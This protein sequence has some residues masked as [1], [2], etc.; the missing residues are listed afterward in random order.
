M[1]HFFL[2]VFLAFPLVLLAQ[3]EDFEELLKKEKSMNYTKNS[4]SLL[5]AY[6]FLFKA[7]YHLDEKKFSDYLTDYFR[8]AKKKKDSEGI[9][10]YFFHSSIHKFYKQDY[11]KAMALADSASFYL[12]NIRLFDF[13]ELSIL[14]MKA[15]IFLDR[16]LEAQDL[17]RKLIED[18]SFEAHPDQLGKVYYY[19]GLASSNST[20]DTG[21]FYLKMAEF[22]LRE[23][24]ENNLLVHIYHAFSE[25]YTKKSDQDSALWYARRSVELAKDSVKYFELDYLL[26]AYNLKILLD[27][28]GS[29]G[30]SSALYNEIQK[31]R[32]KAKVKEIAYPD[33]LRKTSFQEFLRNREEL[34]LVIVSGFLISLVIILGVVI[35]FYSRLKKRKTEL[36]EAL[37]LNKVLYKE[38]NH[39]VKN[40]YQLMI[41]MLNVR[42][43]HSEQTLHQFVDQTKASISSMAKVHDLFLK[44]GSEKTIDSHLFFTEV[45]RSLEESLELNE[46]QITVRFQSTDYRLAT[47]KM[48][49]LGLIINELIINSLKYA[50]RDSGLIEIT[51]DQE[52]DDFVLSYRDNGPGFDKNV[53][54]DKGSGVAIVFSLIKQLRG[55]AQFLNEDGMSLVIRFKG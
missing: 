29:F 41:S 2:F 24:P 6:E 49:N 43:N 33:V 37:D 21:I 52:D 10:L 12:R 8:L 44:K 1:K 36:A 51:L 50:F 55:E 28:S 16:K 54:L 48:V 17:G 39:R 5:K 27:Q 9:G 3:Q 32:Y 26:P 20:P 47:D 42:S 53:I 15:L 13:L 7:Y 19:L 23:Y 45:I 18:S 31:K 40:N 30:E 4:D 14:K 34:Q 38:I 25:L 11:E 46:K 22:Y 35:F